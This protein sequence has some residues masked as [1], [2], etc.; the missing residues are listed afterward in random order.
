M[1]FQRTYHI[2]SALIPERSAL[3]QLVRNSPQWG[4][5]TSPWYV[6][7][8]RLALSAAKAHA[9]VR[10]P[11]HDFSS[12]WDLFHPPNISPFQTFSCTTRLLLCK[13]IK[14]WC[15]LYFFN[16]NFSIGSSVHWPISS[17]CAFFPQTPRYP[18]SWP[19]AVRPPLHSVPPPSV[20]VMVPD[21]TLST[22]PLLSDIPHAEG[23]PTHSATYTSASR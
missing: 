9:D 4:S 13:C 16:L 2:C 19:W 8:A 18:S 15:F 14:D 12:P 20:P 22:C 1:W 7:M 21:A 5:K 3:S 11:L 10:L 17:F 23:L 6:V